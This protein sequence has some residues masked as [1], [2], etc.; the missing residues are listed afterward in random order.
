VP[1]RTQQLKDVNTAQMISDMLSEGDTGVK[2]T[3][4]DNESQS[5]NN[6]FKVAAETRTKFEMSRTAQEINR[7]LQRGMRRN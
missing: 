1:G 3:N 6:K 5:Q 2:L 4:A 7:G